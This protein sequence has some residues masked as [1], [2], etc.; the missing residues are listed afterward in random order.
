MRNN[1]IIMILACLLSANLLWAEGD[2]ERESKIPLG[3]KIEKV[4]DLEILVP[5][6]AKV[7]KTGKGGLISVESTDRY[8]ARELA[9]IKK[10]FEKIEKGYEELRRE[11]EKLRE[12]INK[13]NKKKLISD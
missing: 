8:V 10:R 11:M 4:G 13:S 2:E 3:M 12:T 1:Y 9:D 5:E 6:G 7:N